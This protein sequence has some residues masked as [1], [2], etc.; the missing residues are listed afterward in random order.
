[1]TRAALHL[2]RRP[3]SRFRDRPVPDSRSYPIVIIGSEP[4]SDQNHA[5]RRGC[6]A[7]IEAPVVYA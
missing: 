6:P 7:L 1:M 4:S 2:A 5:S 3:V